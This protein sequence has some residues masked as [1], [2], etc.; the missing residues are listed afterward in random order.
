MAKRETRRVA[1]MLVGVTVGAVARALLVTECLQ[2][3]VSLL[4]SNP[5]ACFCPWQTAC[6]I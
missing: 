6:N 2:A 3:Y 1:V 4:N 5:Q